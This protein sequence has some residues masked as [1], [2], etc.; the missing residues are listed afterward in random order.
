MHKHPISWWELASSD[1]K[2]T[3]EFMRKVFDW[4]LATDEQESYFEQ[5]AGEGGNGFFGG[6][7]YQGEQGQP[8]WLTIYLTVDDVDAKAKEIE[9]AGGKII[10]PPFDVKGLGRLCLFQEPSGQRLAIIKRVF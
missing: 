4:Q 10:D 2:A 5:L 3:V 7:I 9:A 1:A 8:T 6:G